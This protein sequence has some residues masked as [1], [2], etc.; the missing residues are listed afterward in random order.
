MKGEND[1]WKYEVQADGVV[2]KGPDGRDFEEYRW[3]HLVS[4][5]EI[6]L[7]GSIR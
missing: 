3:S 4:H 5:I 6:A 7:R 1:G 2:K